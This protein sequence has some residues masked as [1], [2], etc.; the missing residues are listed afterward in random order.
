M[1]S[2]VG[3]VVPARDEADLI[4]SCLAGIR[5][6]LAQL[7][8]GI[9][10]AVCVVADRCIDDTALVARAELGGWPSAQVVVNQCASTIGEVRDLGFRQVGVMLAGHHA[11]DIWLL[12]TDADTTVEP[13]WATQHLRLARHGT[14]AVA[15]TAELADPLPP[16]VAA[17]YEAI[18]AG[19]HQPDGHGNV[20]AA[21]LGVRA[22]A[23]RAVGGFAPV[24]SGED[25]DLWHRL[26]SAGY[27]L[28]YATEPSVTT[29]A[30]QQGRAPG[31][32]A[33]LL[34][35]LHADDTLLPAAS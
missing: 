35:R 13:D 17:R 33:D 14:H 2:A 7:P 10:R 1:I 22:D 11:D 20:Y 8:P 9:E 29:S 34:S 24:P 4:G 16:A 21:N 26:G 32:V 27:R 18:R 25:Q 3:V 5:H 28:R 23:Y 30:R 31:G 6:A 12:S 19:H 15:G